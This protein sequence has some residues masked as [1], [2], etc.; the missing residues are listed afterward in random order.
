MDGQNTQL[1]IKKHGG[2]VMLVIVLVSSE[3]HE[4]SGNR[5]SQGAASRNKEKNYDGCLPEQI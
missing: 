5:E 3:K 2:E 4:R 1:N